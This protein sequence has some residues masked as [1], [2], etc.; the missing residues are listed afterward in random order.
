MRQ[1]LALTLAQTPGTESHVAETWA[2]RALH[3]GPS[4]D[5]LCLLGDLCRDEGDLDNALAWYNF[6]QISPVRLHDVITAQDLRLRQEGLR[7]ER[8]E[9]WMATA[10]IRPLHFGDA[11]CATQDTLDLAVAHAIETNTP[12]LGGHAPTPHWAFAA[13]D[14]DLAFIAWRHPLQFRLPDVGDHRMH[15]LVLPVRAAPVFGDTLTIAPHTAHLL[16]DVPELTNTAIA[17][18]LPRKTLFGAV[19]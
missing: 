4:R 8:R 10:P 2:L 16:R 15:L 5:A 6:A 19:I 9:N 12:A 13:M 17:S 18:H 14:S 3:D 7:R 11:A 1:H